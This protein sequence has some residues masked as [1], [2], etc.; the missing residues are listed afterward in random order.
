M[1]PLV[2][3]PAVPH[4][5]DLVDAVGEL[6][7]AILDV[8]RSLAVGNIAA[9]HIGNAR[10]GRTPGK[11]A[12]CCDGGASAAKIAARRASWQIARSRLALTIRRNGSS[13]L[14]R[15]EWS[16]A[17]AGD[18]K[19]AGSMTVMDDTRAPVLAAPRPPQE[20][21]SLWQF[22]RTVRDSSIATFPAEA[23]EKDIVPRKLLW[24]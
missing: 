7:A 2:D 21:M 20:R 18:G 1:P 15:G 17:G 19:G 11:V 16:S 22:L 13:V 4:L 6:V 9:V 14:R 10:H 23:Y 3:Q 12:G 24:G 8:D 5:A